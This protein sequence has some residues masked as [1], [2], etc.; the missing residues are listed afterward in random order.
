[1]TH[2]PCH[3]PL[4][5]VAMCFHLE[6]SNFFHLEIDIL[7]SILRFGHAPKLGP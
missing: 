3:E 2:A 1:M 5:L 6:K 7:L 4:T